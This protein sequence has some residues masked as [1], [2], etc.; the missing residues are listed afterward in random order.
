MTTVSE[1]I[2]IFL[3]SDIIIYITVTKELC[4]DGKS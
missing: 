2:Y 4:K 3:N 1:Y